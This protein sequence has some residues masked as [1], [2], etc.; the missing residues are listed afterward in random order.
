MVPIDPFRF[1]VLDRSDEYLGGVLVCLPLLLPAS[2]RI[3]TA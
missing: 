3:L 1:A 2:V